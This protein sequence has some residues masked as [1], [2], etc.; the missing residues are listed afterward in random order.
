M[1]GLEVIELITLRQADA[2]VRGVLNIWTVYNR[3]KDYPSGYIVRRFEMET[4]TSDTFTGS[5][6]SI[7]EAF[8]RCGLSCTSRAHADD[9]CIVETWL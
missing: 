7:R 5:L 4:P 6:D 3:P 1:S 8:M 9:H 2:Q